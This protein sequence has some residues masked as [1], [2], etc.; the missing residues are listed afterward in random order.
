MT[1]PVRLTL[2]ARSAVAA[3][4]S[5]AV[6]W[7]R[8]ACALGKTGR[9]ARKREGDHA[10]PRGRWRILYVLYRPDRCRR[11]RTA[12]PVRP[13]RPADGWCDAS[14]DRNYNR[15]VRLPYPASAERLWRDDGLYDIVVVLDHNTRPRCRDAGSAIFMHI[16]RPDYAPTEGCVA[17]S[18]RDLTAVLLRARP[19][20]VLAVG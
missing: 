19:G 13:I 2:L 1:R 11:P 5:L 18:A 9:R 20:S 14:A 17:L 4:G 7:Q 16:A 6:G 12:L 15:P 3:V 10:T 8:Y